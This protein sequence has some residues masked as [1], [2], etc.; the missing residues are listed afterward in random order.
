MEANFD[1]PVTWEFGFKHFFCTQGETETPLNTADTKNTL[2][3]CVVRN[4]VS[5]AN[6]LY[7]TPHHMHSGYRKRNLPEGDEERIL[8]MLTAAV[9]KGGAAERDV[10]SGDQYR[11][12]MNMRKRRNNCT[13]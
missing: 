12:I 1:L 5:W 4:P 7:R 3:L 13:S 11:N 9:E 6:S 10:R 2:F 8:E